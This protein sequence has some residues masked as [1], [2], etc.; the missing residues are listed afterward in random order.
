MVSL[1]HFIR[2]SDV[3]GVKRKTR[4]IKWVKKIKAVEYATRICV[5]PEKNSSSMGT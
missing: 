4:R 3:S 1:T 5:I 2:F